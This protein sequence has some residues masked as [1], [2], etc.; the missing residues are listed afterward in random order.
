VNAI[1]RI[2]PTGAIQEFPLPGLTA[3]YDSITTGPDGN[4]WFTEYQTSQIGRMTPAGAIQEFPLP[5]A[6]AQATS[7]I[8]GPDGNVWFTEVEANKIGRISPTGAI[9]EFSLPPNALAS[10]TGY[11]GIPG[12]FD[13]T[14]GPDGNLWFTE[15]GTGRIG[16]ITPSG[17]IREYSRPTLLSCPAPGGL[18]SITSGPDGNIWIVCS[19]DTGTEL[20]RLV[21]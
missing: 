7:I 15:Q 2:T 18:D 3:A 4:L 8:A 5:T 6:N 9:R 20:W 12:S 21:P 1:G 14:S 13:I 17:S 10:D 19:R 16:R 11:V